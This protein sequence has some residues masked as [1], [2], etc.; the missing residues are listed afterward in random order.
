[1]VGRGSGL[2]GKALSTISPSEHLKLQATWSEVDVCMLIDYMEESQSKAGDHMSFQKGHF[3]DLLPQLPIQPNGHHKTS[4][5]SST[6]VSRLRLAYLAEKGVD[7][8]T[9]AGQLVIDDLVE[10]CLSFS[11]DTIFLTIH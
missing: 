11:P 2:K 8:V 5:N 6:I 9:E 7:I 3:D 10:V 4:K 1:M